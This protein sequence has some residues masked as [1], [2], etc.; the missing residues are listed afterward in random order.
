MKEKF[1]A[2]ARENHTPRVFQIMVTIL[3]VWF[4]SAFLLIDVFYHLTTGATVQKV[5][6]TILEATKPNR[7]V[8]FGLVTS[9]CAALG[10]L[11]LWL[12]R[13]KFTLIANAGIL[14]VLIDSLFHDRGFVGGFGKY[15]P[16]Y[17]Y[18][19][20]YIFWTMFAVLVVLVFAAIKCTQSG[21][22]PINAVRVMYVDNTQN[23][24]AD[25]IRKLKGLLDDG[26]L[27]EEEFN[28]KKKKLLG[29]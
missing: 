3:I 15:V 24:E 5:G 19:R 23:S 26:I 28:Q 6:Y 17:T 22:R 20:Y 16:V 21:P 8:L 27:S 11:A 2:Y 9:L 13:P 1:A 25:E 12:N 10:I 29:L 14:I 7:P 18:D 4:V